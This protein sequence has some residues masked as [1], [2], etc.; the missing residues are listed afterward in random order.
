MNEPPRSRSTSLRV[1]LALAERPLMVC[2]FAVAQG[3]RRRHRGTPSS[4]VAPHLCNGW[5]SPPGPPAITRATVV[6]SFTPAYVLGN[7]HR[8]PRWD[9]SRPLTGGVDRRTVTTIRSGGGGDVPS[10]GGYSGARL[11]SSRSRATE[12]AAHQKAI[13]AYVLK[14]ID[15]EAAAYTG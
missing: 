15:I 11:E 7:G 10:F 4:A 2:R 9:G 13:G 3:R 1:E 8:N 5:G 12:L 14:T 6:R